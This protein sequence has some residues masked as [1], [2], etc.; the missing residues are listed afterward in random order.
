MAERGR[1]RIRRLETELYLSTGRTPPPPPDVRTPDGVLGTAR[2]LYRTL[3]EL[4]EA[5][6]AAPGGEY[7]LFARQCRADAD[8]VRSLLER[9]R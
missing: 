5:Y 1:R 3:T 9:A 7:E 2:Q 8:R 6:A 4:S